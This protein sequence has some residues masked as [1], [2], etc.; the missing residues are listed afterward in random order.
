MA[1][2][3]Y[4]INRMPFSPINIKSPY[5]LMFEEKPS[6]KHFK[7]FG[8]IC[9]VHVPDA[10]RIKLDAKAQ[11]YI[12]I[13]YDERKK[14]WK[15][16]DPETHKTC[17]SRDV[18]FDEV[19]SYYKA[20]GAI[21]GSTGG[22]TSVHNEL[23]REISLPL[24]PNAPMPLDSS[25]SSSSSPIGEQSN[26]GSSVNG[27]E[28]EGQQGD[29]EVENVPTLRRSKRKVVLPA[30]HKDGNFVSMHSCFLDNPIDE[31]E[32]SSFDEAKGVK[33]RNDDMND[34][35][36]AII[37]NQTWDLMPKPKEVKLITSKWVYKVKQKADD[38]VD[39]YKA[40]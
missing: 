25:S 37:R 20:E 28:L 1:C 9:Y 19:S 4:V 11:K 40:S 16:M 27:H 30:Q 3:T 39:R 33:E 18:V 7:V 38:S 23:H 6:V 36:N 12:F 29:E 17:V 22:D 26:R 13:G 31:C 14:R 2:A 32:L 21:F 24:L 35:I 10:K 15:C 5:E 8:S 34:E